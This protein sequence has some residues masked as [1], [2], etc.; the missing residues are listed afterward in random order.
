[1]RHHVLLAARL[2]ALPSAAMRE[3]LARRRHEDAARLLAI[4]D[5]AS[6]KARREIEGFFDGGGPEE[7]R[8]LR[9]ARRWN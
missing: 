6:P 7:F 4:Y 3:A 9:E 8:R 2:A 1:M 5:G